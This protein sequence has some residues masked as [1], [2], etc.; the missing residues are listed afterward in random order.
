MCVDG[1][2]SEVLDL[3]PT[4]VPGVAKGKKAAWLE[5]CV[6][7]HPGCGGKGFVPC[8]GIPNAEAIRGFRGQGKRHRRT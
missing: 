6:H 5:G 3:K 1:L 4:A 2:G 8:D 7:A